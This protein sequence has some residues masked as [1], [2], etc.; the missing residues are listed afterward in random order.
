MTQINAFKTVKP[1]IYLD[2]IIFQFNSLVKWLF[3]TC[4]TF[5]IIVVNGGNVVVVAFMLGFGGS[6]SLRC[7][8]YWKTNHICFA[9]LIQWYHLNVHMYHLQVSLFYLLKTSLH[10]IFWK[11]VPLIKREK[12]ITKLSSV[13]DIDQRPFLILILSHHISHH[14]ISYHIISYHDLILALSVN[15]S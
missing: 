11:H 6:I 15:M 10:K 8:L 13:H 14:I 12:Q 1:P 4:V 7:V 2:I 3:L 5:V 9:L